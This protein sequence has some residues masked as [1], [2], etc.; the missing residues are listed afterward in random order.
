MTPCTVCAVLPLASLVSCIVSADGS[1]WR[2]CTRFNPQSVHNDSGQVSRL[3]AAHTRLS[4]GVVHVPFHEACLASTALYRAWWLHLVGT[5]SLALDRPDNGRVCSWGLHESQS[6]V[7]VLLRP[8]H[9]HAGLIGAGTN[10]AR[11]AGMLRGLSSYYYK[12]PTLLFLVRAAQG[13]VHMGK[14]LLNLAPKHS[15]GNLISGERACLNPT[16]RIRTGLVLIAPVQVSGVT[17]RAAA[18]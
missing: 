13:L 9:M 4:K 2:L 3:A 10:N 1:H 16:F 5:R 17:H 6:A 18:A 11:L 7:S 12:E 14:G 15:N 8:F